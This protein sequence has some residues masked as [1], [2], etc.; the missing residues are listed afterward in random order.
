MLPFHTSPPTPYSIIP[1]LSPIPVSASLPSFTTRD[2][3]FL[4]PAHAC[5]IIRSHRQHFSSHQR[6]F[7][8][9][10]LVQS[11]E[12]F[13]ALRPGGPFSSFSPAV[14]EE[15]VRQRLNDACDAH[16]A[17]RTPPAGMELIVTVLFVPLPSSSSL[18]SSSPST[19]WCFISHPRFA[20]VFPSSV[21]LIAVAL[22]PH[23]R[24]LPAYKHSQWIRDRQPLE[25]QKLVDEVG[26]ILMMRRS[27]AAAEAEEGDEDEGEVTEGLLT[28]LIAVESEG[29]GKVR[30]RLCR[31]GQRLPGYWE[32]LVIESMGEEAA[33]G[34]L[35]EEDR[36]QKEE[37]QL[38][39]GLAT[40]AGG[41]SMMVERGCISV[42]R[43]KQGGYGGLFITGSGV[44][45]AGVK[46]V[47]WGGQQ[48][49]AGGGAAAGEVG[50]VVM[51]DEGVKLVEKVRL[52]MLRLLDKHVEDDRAAAAAGRH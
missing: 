39:N 30:L 38:E 52:R 42:R 50:E 9:R 3:L 1:F 41:G 7:H 33:S 40:G 17:T 26:E 14:T 12:A 11:A 36:E 25:Q 19:P 28:N 31:E 34:S 15:T 21:P 16:L 18:P 6:R 43:L 4:F 46:K 51:G 29:Q 35:R 45:I 23:C 27:T 10:R 32:S 48:G 49:D 24:L 8:A 13:S 44:C 2:F 22:H 47:K 37:R 20:P 5:T